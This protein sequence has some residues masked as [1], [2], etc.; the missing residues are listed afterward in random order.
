MTS[1]AF[2][3]MLHRQLQPFDIFDLTRHSVQ[4]VP[5]L[6]TRSPRPRRPVPG[7]ITERRA[8]CRSCNKRSSERLQPQS[9]Q[10]SC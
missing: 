9:F 5:P 10:A 2:V 7:C 3:Q 8:S 6:S 1:G 4:P